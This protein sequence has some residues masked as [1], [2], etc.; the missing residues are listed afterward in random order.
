METERQKKTEKDRQGQTDRETERRNEGKKGIK[1]KEDND[2][3]R[4]GL[5]VLSVSLLS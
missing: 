2:G 3:G 5:R 4:E 1:R